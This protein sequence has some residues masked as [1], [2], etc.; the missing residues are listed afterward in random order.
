MTNVLGMALMVLNVQ[1][2]EVVAT[3]YVSQSC[4]AAGCTNWV[5]GEVEVEDKAAVWE[6]S[7]QVFTNSY[8]NMTSGKLIQPAVT[9]KERVKMCMYMHSHPY[10]WTNAVIVTT[11]IG[12]KDRPLFDVVDVKAFDDPGRVLYVQSVYYRDGSYIQRHKEA[13]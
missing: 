6:Y 13:P 4:E 9:H 2:Q 7:Q 3:N 8:L 10:T 1:T 11:V 5:W 12:T